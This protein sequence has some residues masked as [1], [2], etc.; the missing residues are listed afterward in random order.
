MQVNLYATF[1]L[2]AGFKHLQID[3]PQGSTI[4]TLVLAIVDQYPV[5]R[6]HWLDIENQLHA[7][8]HIFLNGNEITT[9]PDDLQTRLNP[10]DVVDFFPPVAG[11]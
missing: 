1:R 9:L 4:Y 3:L 7:H 10:A 8:V 5:L 6:T 2:A 11:G